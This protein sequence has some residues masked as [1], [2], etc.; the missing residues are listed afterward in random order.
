[1]GQYITQDG[2]RISIFSPI[3]RQEL[4]TI[5]DAR[6]WDGRSALITDSAYRELQQLVLD[7]FSQE[8]D[9]YILGFIS[10]FNGAMDRVRDLVQNDMT[11]ETVWNNLMLLLSEAARYLSP[12]VADDEGAYLRLPEPGSQD[13]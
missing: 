13:N 7:A 8:S 10:G 9:E 1:M 4:A 5:P 2:R 12:E 3:T 11:Y 6:D